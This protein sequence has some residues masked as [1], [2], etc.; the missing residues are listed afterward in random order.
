MIIT[1]MEW[2]PVDKTNNHYTAEYSGKGNQTGLGFTAN[3]LP[4]AL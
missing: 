2:K 4:T 3:V 1:D